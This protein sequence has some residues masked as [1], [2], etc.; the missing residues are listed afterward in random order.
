MTQL[1]SIA[2]LRTSGLLAALG[3]LF[4]ILAGAPGTLHA[5]EVGSAEVVPIQ[6]NG[7]PE[8]FFTLVILGDGYTADEMDR[9]REH[10]DKHLNV[11]W[12]IE[13]F[14][15][16][17]NYIN[18]FAVEI[19]SGESGIDC[20]PE[21]REERETPLGMSF[22]GGCSNPNARGINVGAAEARRY[23]EMAT[24]HYNQ[25]LAIANT[26]TYGGRG[27]A[28]A[29]TSGGNSL[30]PLI[31][32]HELG[33]SLGR[34]QDEYTYRGRGVPGG[35]Y[36]G[37]EPG[38]IHHTLMTEAEILQR[39]AKWWRWL[40]EESEAG[41]VIGRFE[42]GQSNRSGTWRPAQHSMMIS[43]GYYF[44]EV[45]R[46]RMTA[47]ISEEA[48]L[49]T[50]ST[51]NDRPVST[52]GVVWVAT[53][54]P[55]Y[56]ELDV[57]WRVNGE[58][59][60]SAGDRRIL[61]LSRLDL[62][63]G[64]HEISVRVSD[65]TAYVRDPEVRERS[66][67]AIRSWTATSA[68]A[69]PQ[70]GASNGAN[71][72]AEP[73]FTGHTQ[74]ERPVGGTDVVFV[75]TTQPGDRVLEVRWTLNGL[76][77]PVPEGSRHFHLAHYGLAEGT[78]TLR[79]TVSDPMNPEGE[80]ESL[81]WVV[82]NT[83]P[84][85]AYTLS[86]ATARAPRPDGSTHYFMRDDFTMALDATDDQPG[87]VV[88]EFRLNGD[89]WHHYYGWP[90]APE[91]TP[92]HFTPR[93]TNIKELVYG[94]LSSEGLSPQPWEAREPGWGTHGI[95]YRGI[96]AAGNIGEARAFHVSLYPSPECTTT[97]DEDHD[98]ELHVERGTTCVG[99]VR[100]EGGVRVY[101]GASLVATDAL[102]RGPVTTTGAERV[103]LLGTTVEG[104]LRITGSRERVTIF[105]ST[106]LGALLLEGNRTGSPIELVGSTVTGRVACR[107][108]GDAPVDLGTP[109]TL[110]GPIAG[111][112]TGF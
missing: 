18:V 43:L 22:S 31:T 80:S 76:E 95:E 110:R 81:T 24:P 17:R 54:N 58:V 73:G 49:I 34:L 105:G 85:V 78:H 89:G 16:Y 94:S 92:F 53:A 21:I 11:M 65:P 82:D 35:H 62:E 12:S 72:A 109:G 69:P 59:V 52:G 97:V 29:T 99:A 64:E 67:T 77:V 111:A 68:V 37:G 84:S 100:I 60:R 57:I 14:R 101:P 91:G 44:D 107:E 108:N 86:E 1:L 63:S 26:D 75:E 25:L 4:P 19:V 55:V 33:H 56:H 106:V 104:T 47:R 27:G 7:D 6:V 8:S 2:P 83:P 36:R 46:E 13:P 9:F 93:G 15:S 87:Y 39:Q 10:V 88:A 103:E 23:A 28:V 20:D 41:G 71:G 102:I 45:S 5:Q 51:P 66:L 112:C 74:T 98:G 70:A 38:S 32:P 90:D 30:G 61:D 79:A 42:G 96:D 48:E 40:G 50:A 3:L